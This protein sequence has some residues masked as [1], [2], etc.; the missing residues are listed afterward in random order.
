[1]P[2]AVN[3]LR[4]VISTRS[5][6]ASAAASRSQSSTGSRAP[7]SKSTIA[8]AIGGDGADGTA[9]R[10]RIG[11]AEQQHVGAVADLHQ[12]DDLVRLG[13][14][15]RMGQQQRGVRRA[16][17]ADDAG[18]VIGDLVHAELAAERLDGPRVR[19]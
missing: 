4:N 10:D 1:M 6:I 13:R 17:L 12:R 11:G 19:T 5:P 14:L 7:L 3:S 16:G 8:N 15:E 9:R 18:E 2:S